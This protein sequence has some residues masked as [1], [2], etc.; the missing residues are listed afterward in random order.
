M[1]RRL[2]GGGVSRHVL[3]L[4]PDAPSSE[5]A[6]VAILEACH[7]HREC[8]ADPLSLALLP[9]V[10]ADGIGWKSTA[11]WLASPPAGDAFG[12]VTL[13]SLVAQT[14]T[15]LATLAR[16]KPNVLV[17]VACVLPLRDEAPKGERTWVQGDAVEAAGAAAFCAIRAAAHAG[18]ACK[19]TLV[20]DGTTPNGGDGVL[21]K[22]CSVLEPNDMLRL[23]ADA[24][25]A[26]NR[27]AEFL[28]GGRHWVG[29]LRLGSRTL[30]GLV[31][32]P[33]VSS[34]SVRNVGG[35]I[36]G[37]RDA[38]SRVAGGGGAS[39][40][41]DAAGE[42]NSA[43]GRA[44]S[45]LRRARVHLSAELMEAPPPG[46]QLELIRVVHES[47]LPAHLRMEHTWTLDACPTEGSDAARTFLCSW[48]ANT[49]KGTHT[50]A[51]SG[52][53]GG[54]ADAMLVRCVGGRPSSADA[55]ADGSLLLLLYSRNGAMRAQLCA[56]PD[57]LPAA[58]RY[59][60]LHPARKVVAADTDGGEGMTDGVVAAMDG[61]ARVEDAGNS[62]LVDAL[63]GLIDD[64]AA[65]VSR[66]TDSRHTDTAQSSAEWQ[67]SASSDGSHA[68][69][70][71]A[72]CLPLHTARAALRDSSGARDGAA[73][74]DDAVGHGASL[75]EAPDVDRAWRQ[76]RHAP[77]AMAM[78]STIDG[79][80]GDRGD[81]DGDSDD[82]DATA[83]LTLAMTGAHGSSS[84]RH[85][86]PQTQQGH[87]GLPGQPLP[88]RARVCGGSAVRSASAGGL[89]RGRLLAGAMGGAGPAPASGTQAGSGTLGGAALDAPVAA[90]AGLAAA[91]TVA[92]ST[93]AV[94]SVPCATAPAG[95]LPQAAS[96]ARPSA[97]H[98]AP[99]ASC[100]ASNAAEAALG[101][102]L[103]SSMSLGFR[104]KDVLRALRRSRDAATNSTS[105]NAANDT[106]LNGTCS[107]SAEAGSGHAQGSSTGAHSP[108]PETAKETLQLY[109]PPIR[110]EYGSLLCMLLEPGKLELAAHS[111]PRRGSSTT[112]PTLATGASHG[113]TYGADGASGGVA[114]AAL[115][116]PMRD[117][118]VAG[119]LVVDPVAATRPSSGGA[120][121]EAELLASHLAPRLPSEGAALPSS[122]TS[123]ASEPVS[124]TSLL[125]HRT[126]KRILK[127]VL[128]PLA[129]GIPSGADWSEPLE[130]LEQRAL[131]AIERREVGLRTVSEHMRHALIARAV[132]AEIVNALRNGLL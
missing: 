32:R 85:A 96:G 40:N 76:L 125:V 31:L 59:L 69:A 36:D 99:H 122:S 98:A 67:E 57:S 110:R 119:A 73:G 8:G 121:A 64:S 34:P 5:V 92:A 30:Q 127:A 83:M 7:A 15:L 94:G 56:A 71:W 88:Q 130:H 84:K 101:S 81:G 113:A 78:G 104:M 28:D 72:R 123:L 19:C 14:S 116:P 33:V 44:E 2:Q 25:L 103:S 3:V 10:A 66:R 100:A 91:G 108:S 90:P 55:R 65:P 41:D 115:A 22:W 48:A 17:E 54:A 4:A 79:S 61:E 29:A 112:A 20:V 38:D 107:A 80:S 102:S 117:L 118:A 47:H 50:A 128:D 16:S 129:D 49:A 45:T 60:Q 24:R 51:Q 11:A 124:S 26:R 126:A 120:A 109:T 18:L 93:T 35:A 42:D 86:P 70:L 46:S 95:E 12:E 97:L 43:P 37:W 89:A 131:L 23:P 52:G 105:A 114:N 132:R 9:A 68:D 13:A 77:I 21:T 87:A 39:G 111:Q 6:R 75:W 53:V 27:L 82:G 63:G 62:A 106:N 58:L 1:A 74:G